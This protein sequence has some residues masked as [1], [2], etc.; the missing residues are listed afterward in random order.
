MLKLNGNV[1]GM[2]EQKYVLTK[3]TAIYNT[4]GTIKLDDKFIIVRSE[5]ATFDIN[6]NI[7]NLKTSSLVD[8]K[9]NKMKDSMRVFYYKNDKLIGIRN[10]SENKP[11]DSF[12]FHYLRKG[13]LDYYRSFD[14]NGGVDYKMTYVYKGKK[15]FTIR[16]KDKGNF[17]IAMIKLK[18]KEDRISEWEYYDKEFRNTET[19][20]FSYKEN[21]DGN[22]D[23][24]YAVVDGNGTLRGGMTLLKDPS[25]NILEQSVVDSGRTVTA[26]F[27]Y[28]YDTHQNKIK[29]K[30]YLG[31]E[32]ANVENRYTYDTHDNWTRKE[33]FTN[34]VLTAIVTRSYNYGE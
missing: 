10:I 33:I 30:I 27:Q 6:G 12:E 34:D 17:A 22:F 3:D 26:Y 21:K 7:L 24:S 5:E 15:V 23:E 4:I 18:Y 20:R 16:K 32:Q 13:L 28:Q 11:A 19:R 14:V 1:I 2:K 29:E 31:L 25:G 8:V 9:R